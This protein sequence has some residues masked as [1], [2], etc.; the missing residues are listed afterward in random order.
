[1]ST[2]KSL[3]NLAQEILDVENEKLYEKFEQ[4][5]EEFKRQNRGRKNMTR[6]FDLLRKTFVIARDEAV[7][8]AN[9][10]W[11]LDVL[12]NTSN[13]KWQLWVLNQGGI[14]ISKV[15][16]LTKDDKKK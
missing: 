13:G 2:L 11:T 4:F 3:N 8:V 15:R 1:M 14:K 10:M 6:K 5:E 12:C 7:M 16:F 9:R